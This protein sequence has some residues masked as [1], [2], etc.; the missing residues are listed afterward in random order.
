M[1]CAAHVLPSLQ[2]PAHR[3]LPTEQVHLCSPSVTDVEEGGE[4]AFPYGRWLDAEKQAAPPYTECAA[5]GTA[6][7]PRKG[8]AVLFFSLKP[9]GGWWLGEKG[10]SL[11]GTLWPP[12]LPTRCVRPRAAAAGCM[13]SYWLVAAVPAAG[14]SALRLAWQ[15][16]PHSRHAHTPQTCMTDTACPPCYASPILLRV[17]PRRQEEGRVQL[18]RRLPR[19]PWRQVLSHKLGKLV[20]P[21]AAEAAAGVAALLLSLVDGRAFNSLSLV[22]NS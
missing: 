11:E 9:D 5:R 2:L 19:G 18:P 4:T 3:A 22:P 13:R 12:L 21:F 15:V 10:R 8:D 1:G 20:A 7:K 14:C 17:H 16:M 6:V